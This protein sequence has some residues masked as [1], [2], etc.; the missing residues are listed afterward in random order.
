MMTKRIESTPVTP[1]QVKKLI[2]Y[3]REDCHL[4]QEMIVALKNFQVQVSFEFHVVDID[5]DPEL[6]VLYGEKIP[7]LMSPLT[8]QLICHYF[9]DVAALDGYLG[10]FG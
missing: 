2:V 4:C 6:I 3:G 9:L 8:N 1:D 10:E 7:V 5:S